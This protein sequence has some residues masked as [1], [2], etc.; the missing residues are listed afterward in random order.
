MI[1]EGEKVIFLCWYELWWV[2]RA[3]SP[4]AIHMNSDYGTQ[5]VVNKKKEHKVL[6]GIFLG[7]WRRAVEVNIIIMHSTSV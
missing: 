1:V 4:T 2:A 7:A 6:R 3:D 5:W